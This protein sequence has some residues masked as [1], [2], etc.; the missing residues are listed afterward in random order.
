MLARHVAL[1]SRTERV[2][3]DQL[4]VAAAAIQKQITRDFGPIWGIEADV[5]AF[6]ELSDVP[7][8]YWPIVIYDRIP[9]K[10]AQGIHL[11]KRNGQP[12]ALV[13]FSNNWTLTT[14]H[15]CL[16]MLADPSGNRTQAG[17]SVKPD[18]GRVEYLVEVCDPCEAAQYAYSVNG[19]LVSDFY[20][21]NFFDP[22]AVPGLR[23]SFTGKITEPRKVLDGG[24]LSWVEPETRHLWQLF[25]EG[26]KPDFKD[27]GVLPDNMENLRS[28]S[29]RIS[30]EHR[31][32]AIT[33]GRIREGLVLME[34]IPV[35]GRPKRHLDPAHAAHGEIIR[36]AIRPLIDPFNP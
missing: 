8:G 26:E 30:E 18:Q 14:S 1:I 6:A 22:I 34:N 11:N 27:G 7:L 35:V 29:D 3:L 15:E 31:K 17:N 32:R 24:Y 4:V 36:E 10:G 13:Q 25:V 9:E 21:P 12:F 16:E 20:T 23:Y 28:L 33:E 2:G 19:V 5:A